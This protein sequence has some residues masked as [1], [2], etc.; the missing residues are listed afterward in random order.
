MNLLL[1]DPFEVAKEYPETLTS[2]LQF[3]HSRYIKFNKNGDYLASGLVDG[4][5]SIFDYDTSQVVCALKRHTAVIQ[6]LQWSRCGRYLLSSSTDCNVL[7]WDLKSQS[8]IR[9]VIFES[10]VWF[11]EMHPKD[12]FIFIASIFNSEPVL[13]DWHD[14]ENVMEVKLPTEPFIPS[15]NDEEDEGQVEEEQRLKRRKKLNDLVL[16]LTFAFDA[17]YIFTGTSKGWLNILQ[18]RRNVEDS[19]KCQFHTIYSQ[20]A[21][22]SHIKQIAVTEKNYKIF[23]NCSDRIIRQLSIAEEFVNDTP[24]WLKTRDEEFEIEHKYQDV[25]NRLQWNSVTTNHNGDY[26]IASTYGSGAHDIYMWET[27]M[28]SLI[29]VL[30]GPKEELFDIDWNDKRC[31]IGANGLDS[32][33]IYLWT[34]I[35]PQ[36]W[37]AL[38]PDFVEVEENVEYEEREDEFDILPDEELNQRQMDLEDETVDIITRDK[39]DARGLEEEESF[40]IPVRYEIEIEAPEDDDD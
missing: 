34:N 5:I 28:G 22:S 13:V 14:A 38:A 19:D 32:G 4:T 16:C 6:S 37:S 23:I 2:T 29:K 25:V 15:D 3:G 24:K 17:G 12:P 30:E 33:Y 7:L 26:L 1:L 31:C 35:I 39:V 10:P 27:T 18:Y 8:V 9:E 21:T 36:K 11:A 20:K 40:V